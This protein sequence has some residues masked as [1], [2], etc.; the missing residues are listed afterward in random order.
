[1][2]SNWCAA[3]SCQIPMASW[4]LTVAEFLRQRSYRMVLDGWF[5]TMIAL[6]RG[7]G[8]TGD[9]AAMAAS[10]S[11]KVTSTVES[12]HSIDVT[13]GEHIDSMTDE[14]ILVTSITTSVMALV[15][16]D[17]QMVTPT[18]VNLLED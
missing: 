8:V 18:S 2:K 7:I 15:S 5:I 6:S 16:S 3:R 11:P 1:M 14:S 17:G 12:M 9:G 4:V 10:L 13:A